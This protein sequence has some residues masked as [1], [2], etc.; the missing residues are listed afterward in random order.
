MDIYNKSH[1]ADPTA[2]K[3]IE[4]ADKVP[5]EII[6]YIILIKKAAK[7]AGIKITKRVELEYK[8][9]IYR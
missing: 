5:D 1:A 3:A 4:S 9:K 6:D 8:G 7:L 2:K